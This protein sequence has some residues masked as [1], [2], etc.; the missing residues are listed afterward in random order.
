[1]GSPNRKDHGAMPQILHSWLIIL[2]LAAK[3][4]SQNNCCP[5]RT[6]LGSDGNSGVYQLTSD[7]DDRCG[8]GCL[9]TKQNSADSSIC[10]QPSSSGSVTSG[11]P[12]PSASCPSSTTIAVGHLTLDPGPTVALPLTLAP[13]TAVNQVN[14]NNNNT[15]ALQT[16]ATTTTTTTTTTSLDLSIWH[17]QSTINPASISMAGDWGPDEFCPFGAYATGFELK[18]APLCSRR[19][20]TDDDFAI[21]ATRL[22][23]AHYLDPDT[24]VATVTST[25]S[26]AGRSGGGSSL[27][28]SWFS[29]QS[30]PSSSWITSSRY[31]SEVFMLDNGDNGGTTVA[32]PEGIICN[33]GGSTASGNDPA[34]GVNMDVRC[35]DGTELLGNSGISLGDKAGFYS[36]SDWEECP[37]GTAVCGIRTRVQEGETDDVSNLGQT[38]VILHCCQIP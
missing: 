20:R 8:D 19:C 13:T 14:N 37:A 1:M 9:Y 10:F 26:T 36:L 29:L 31:L 21:G 2:L 32:C 5:E 25:V 22:T 7:S 15:V 38:E 27:G 6:V 33:G 30:C 35:S 28:Y 23:C 12:S 34:G 24:P 18:V 3:V 4:L 11:G 17:I 16:T